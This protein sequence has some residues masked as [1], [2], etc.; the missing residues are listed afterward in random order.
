MAHNMVWTEQDPR[1]WGDLRF[2]RDP[3]RGSATGLL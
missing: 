3:P 2:R 1:G